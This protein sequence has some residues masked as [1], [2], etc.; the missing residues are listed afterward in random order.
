MTILDRTRQAAPQIAEILRHRILTLDL[1]PRTVLSRAALQLEFGVSQTP[2]RDAL[3]QLADEGLVHIY[4]QASTLVSPI[5]PEQALQAHFLRSAIEIEA[6][7]KIV[8][9]GTDGL[10]GKLR[11]II[12]DQERFCEAEDYES[13][14]EEDR[15]FHEALYDAA[16]IS[17]LWPLV[18]RHSVHIDRLRRL[19]LPRP[20]KMQLVLADHIAITDAIEKADADEAGKTMRK[21]LS[22]T[23]ALIETMAR[24]NPGFLWTG[25]PGKGNPPA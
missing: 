22:G 3:Q 1:A 5:D 7:R 18:R 11:R 16:G 12:A 21:H 23:I 8:A 6:I 19:H 2:V 4:P 9:A 20:G 10:G 25:G 13:F 24:E 17:A 15:R 14:D